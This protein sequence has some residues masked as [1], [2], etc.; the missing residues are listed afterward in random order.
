MRNIKFFKNDLLFNLVNGRSTKQFLF[1]SVFSLGFSICVILCTFGLMDGFENVLKLSLRKSS[2]DL[3]V[4]SRE[5]FYQEKELFEIL[6]NQGISAKTS[7]LNS[8]GFLLFNEASKGISLKGIDQVSFSQ[9][10][11]LDVELTHDSVAIGKE[12]ASE[13]GI[14][15]ND[16][17]VLVLGKGNEALSEM[18]LLVRAKVQSI[19][20]HGIYEKDLRIIYCDQRYLA[21]LLGTNLKVNQSLLKVNSLDQ[22]DSQV[23]L[24]N[25]NLPYEYIIKPY[26]SEFSSMLEAV[27]VEKLSISIVLQLIVIVSIFNIIA[28]I[29]YLNERRVKEI[30]LL[31]ALGFSQN[32]LV[33]LWMKL[34]FVIWVL[35]CIVSVLM[36]KIFS[37]M[38]INLKILK[39][40]PQIYIL[41]N[42]GLQI[43]LESYAI[44]FSLA[45]AWL[46]LITGIL[47]FK[48]KS[49]SIVVELKRGF[50][51]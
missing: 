4:T 27:K 48:Y 12:L 24:L 43:S 1:A 41:E 38:L 16:E 11:G 42:F 36:T 23:K 50:I 21:E 44:V 40:P 10:T 6:P 29:M 47:V 2:G 25:K 35:A 45:L 13:L 28:F 51:S 3:I 15:L 19:I 14:Q 22:I 9:V 5:G 37:W 30:F 17:I 32:K 18:P 7:V 46:I 34:V 49:K 39:L 33:L 26:W 8:E 31:K 20:S